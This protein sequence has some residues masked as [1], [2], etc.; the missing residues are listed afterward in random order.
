MLGKWVTIVTVLSAGALALG[1]SASREVEVTGSVSGASSKGDVVLEFFDVEG[2]EKTSVHTAK[3][4]A[5]GAFSEKVELAGEKVLVR[6]IGDSDGDGAC[7]A[8]ELWGEV[9][10]TIEEDA[11]KVAITLS[12]AACPKEE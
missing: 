3:A 11:A 12:V 2:E 10:A 5:D 6:A 4:G 9:T 8:G 7:S 1:C